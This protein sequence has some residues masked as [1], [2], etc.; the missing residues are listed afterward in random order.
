MVPPQDFRVKISTIVSNQ[1]WLMPRLDQCSLPPGTSVNRN[2]WRSRRKSCMIHIRTSR[3]IVQKEEVRQTKLPNKSNDTVI[4]ATRPYGRTRY[5][6]ESRQGHTLLYSKAYYQMMECLGIVL[7]PHSL[8]VDVALKE[9]ATGNFIYISVK[10]TTPFTKCKGFKR[11]VPCEG[12]LGDLNKT[13]K[14]K[15]NGD[16]TRYDIVDGTLMTGCA[17]AVIEN[18]V[19]QRG[20][21]GDWSEFDGLFLD[22]SRQCATFDTMSKLFHETLVTWQVRRKDDECASQGSLKASTS[23]GAEPSASNADHDDKDFKKKGI[24]KD[25]GNEMA[26]YRDSMTCDMPNFDGTL[27]PIANTRWLFAVECA[28]QFQTLMKTNKTMNELQKKFNDLIPYCLEYHGNEKLKVKRLQRML[29]D[30]IR[31]KSKEVKKTKRK[32]KFKDQDAK[33]H[34]H[35]HGRKGGGNQTKTLCKSVINFILENAGQT[36]HVATNVVL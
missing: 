15:S 31:E 23:K 20:H 13:M 32:L 6:P 11:D 36:Y 28:F 21:G 16:L 22:Y 33:K 24:M 5:F 18:G 1:P 25:F 30:D 12:I 17:M 34:K 2:T 4:K 8:K 10:A 7:T 14:D 35:D 27:D 3:M 29:R 9:L 19:D 26:T